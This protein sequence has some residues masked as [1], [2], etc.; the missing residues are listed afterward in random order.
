MI[1]N[2]DKEK[3]FHSSG[4]AKVAHGV[5]C[6]E[7]RFE[8]YDCNQ[9]KRTINFVVRY[10]SY[11]CR[12]GFV[13]QNYKDV[14]ELIEKA[15]ELNMDNSEIIKEIDKMEFE[16]QEMDNIYLLLQNEGI[17]IK[18]DLNV[19]EIAELTGSQDSL[20][21]YLRDISKIPLLTQEE[22]LELAKKIKNG[23]PKEKKSAREKMIT[24]NLRLVVSIAKRFHYGKLEM[25]DLIQEGTLGLM[26]AIDKYDYTRGYRFSTY[27]TW[28]VRQAI[29]RAIADKGKSVRIPI[30]MHETI[31]KLK[32]A[33]QKLEQTLD[34]EPTP[35]Q[36]AEEMGLPVKKVKN[37]M[38]YAQEVVSLDS[39]V[40]ENDMTI[41]SFLEDQSAEEDFNK[42]TN[43]ELHDRILDALGTLTWREKKIMCMRYGIGINRTYTLEEIGKEFNITRE[44]VRQIETK[45]LK[46]LRHSSRSVLLEGFME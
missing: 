39:P 37:A 32:K 19:S 18:E 41:A 44:R 29:S 31:S 40:N 13:V 9:L 21:L 23:T 43:D 14:L 42:V 20:K 7:T 27:A 25:Q 38:E 36:I 10:F 6:P 16:E 26:K 24:A 34:N 17:D 8:S 2:K 35:E 22:E 46:K 28:W 33:K 30:H 1:Y 3:S 11:I 4:G 5:H 45:A 12:R 15:K